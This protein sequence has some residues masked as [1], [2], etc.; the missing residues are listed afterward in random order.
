[1]SPLRISI[2]TLSVYTGVVI[3]TCWSQESAGP[4]LADQL[5]RLPPVEPRAA[6]ATFDVHEDFVLEQV[7]AEPLVADPVDACFDE[8][9]RM[10]VAEMHGYPYSAEKR[11]QCPDGIGKPDAGIIRLLEDTDDD[12]VMDRSTIYAE[13]LSWPQSVCCYAGGVFVLAPPHLYYLADTN[14]DDVA[15][16]RQIVYSGF[17]RTNVQG[18]ANNLKWGPDFKIY[19]AGGTGGA[20]LTHRDAKLFSLGRR[21]FRFDPRTEKLEAVAGGGQFGQS[22]DEWGNRFVCSNSNHIQHVTTRLED[23]QQNPQLPATAVLKS[24]AKEGPAAP[25][26]RRSPA[27]PWRIVRTRRRAADPNYQRRLPKTELVPTG[28]FTSATGVTI[29]RGDAYPAEF[30]GN[31]FIGDVGGNL[32]HRKTLAPAGISFLATRADKQREFITST[33]TWFRP[34]NFVNAPDGTLYIL[35]MYRETIEHPYSIPADIKKYLDLESGNDRGRIYRIRH[36]EMSREKI[37]KPGKMSN[38]E[39]VELLGSNVAWERD[40]AGR[41][42]W[43]RKAVDVVKQ[44]RQLVQRKNSPREKLSALHLLNSLNM[45]DDATLLAGMRDS[46]TAAV[47]E[48]AVDLADKQLA[49]S[50]KLVEALATLITDES[51]RV[52]RQVIFAG[53]HAQPADAARL[54]V[55]SCAQPLSGEL[56][57]AVRTSAWSCVE[58]LAQAFNDKEVSVGMTAA[59]RKWLL[60]EVAANCVRQNRNGTVKQLIQSATQAENSAKQLLILR[61][62]TAGLQSMQKRTTLLAYLAEQ[63]GGEAVVATVNQ[64]VQRAIATA[65]DDKQSLATRVSAMELLAFGDWLT[66]QPVLEKLLDPVHP[67]AIQLQ[68][69][70]IARSQSHFD[71]STALVE[72]F[73]R[74][75]PRVREAAID[76]LLARSTTALTLA[77]ALKERKFVAGDL[78]VAQ[79]QQLLDHAN[80]TAAKTARPLLAGPRNASRS[81]VLKEYRVALDLSGDVANGR[82]LFVKQCANCHRAEDTGYRVGP[83]ITSVKN[84]SPDDLLSA[85]LDPNRERQPNYTAYNIATD[86]GQTFSGIVQTESETAVALLQPQAKVVS[87][88]RA[89]IAAMKSTNKSLMPEGLERDLKPQDLADLIA[90]IQ[91]QSQAKSTNKDE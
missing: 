6:L 30:Q 87:V 79:R 73:S 4:T 68:A 14:N 3:G 56:Q 61:G 78:T 74:L 48:C 57:L 39:L 84:K 76:S 20:N 75:T 63:P 64:L 38:A 50:P 24:I 80:R 19:G 44:L 23:L 60:P 17:Q 81:A 59:N 25:V 11:P 70:H 8:R 45:L 18:L 58:P 47:R 32:V 37:L 21:N 28:Y 65:N 22:F 40:T 86:D 31:A 55:A 62:I 26:Y 52:R 10:F 42:L 12:G 85:I 41:L 13:N 72:Q 2:V 36:K 16:V 27:E 15:D 82:K 43:E 66:V 9:G 69:I 53:G 77:N 5:K 34:V 90:Y 71:L 35:D 7:A 1:M 91:Q 83:D 89:R 46:S 29:Y 88:L 51:V 67:A 49:E 54:I 33:D